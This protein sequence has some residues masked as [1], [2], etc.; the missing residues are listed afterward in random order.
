MIKNLLWYKKKKK[1]KTMT[2]LQQIRLSTLIDKYSDTEGENKTLIPG[3]T[4]FKAF[5]KGTLFPSIY[6]PCICFIAQGYKQVML[7]KE[8]YRYGP[9]ES[10]IVSVDLPVI[11]QVLKASET[12]PYL[13]VQIDIEPEQLSEL[14]LQVELPAIKTSSTDRGL[15]VCQSDEM[16]SDSIFRL[17]C[18]METPQ[19]IPVLASQTKREILYRLLQSTHGR[20]IAQIAIKNSRFQKISTVIQD[21]KNNLHHRLNADDLAENCGMSVSSFYTHFKSVTAMSP[22]QFQKS[23]R[24]MEARNLMITSGM[25]AAGSAYQVGYESPSQFSREYTR[26]FGNPPGR[27]IKNVMAN[28]IK[29]NPPF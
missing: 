21:I 20:K 12:R 18:L 3:V 26:M 29:T 11:S 24:L 14:L 25:D 22:L 13:V 2:K 7:N 17:L 10:L 27:D 19:D 16:I 5:T 4:F 8:I 6:T 1:F 15:F 9:L 28:S 23:L